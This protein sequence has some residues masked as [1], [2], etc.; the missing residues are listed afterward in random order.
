MVIVNNS[1]ILLLQAEYKSVWVL[2]LL[3]EGL[4]QRLSLGLIRHY[5]VGFI[6]NTA[7]LL[8]S[9]LQVLDVLRIGC[10][11]RGIQSGLKIPLLSNLLVCTNKGHL[12]RYFSSARVNV[13]KK[14][15]R[16]LG[17]WNFL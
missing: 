4:R 16:K 1:D 13:A 5:H 14:K 2:A 6:F 10:L 8:V 3:V 11:T 7:C 9:P 12:L 17:G 15:K